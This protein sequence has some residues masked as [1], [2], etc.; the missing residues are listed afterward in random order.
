MSMK[1]KL[2]ELL[3]VLASGMVERDAAMRL[4]LLAALSGEHTLLI[5]P[6]GTAKSLLAERLH[7]AFTDARFF[8]RLVNKF[9]V[10]EDLFGPF[11]LQ[12]LDQGK[13]ERVTEGYMP[14]ASVVFLDEIFKANPAILNSLL[15]ILHER[16][17]DNGVERVDVPLIS[18]VAAS[19]ELPRPGELDA[20]FDRFLVR[21]PVGR[22]TDL[23]ALFNGKN[24][25]YQLERD[26]GPELARIGVEL[27]IQTNKPFQRDHQMLL[28]TTSHS[29]KGYEAEVVIVVGADQF[30]AKGA[31]VLANNLYVAMTRARS[32][33]TL[34][35][36]SRKHAE[37]T[38]LNETLE[39]CLDLLHERPAFAGE[40]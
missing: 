32:V 23:Q 39:S 31:G 3:T 25:R 24:I 30:C 34:F 2:Q 26:V 14:E 19:N 38:L 13:F 35:S 4:T 7:L 5:G 17:F 33:L 8:E 36:Q 11:N 21:C 28:A 37:G 9:T 1:E 12:Q 22:V 6:P 10:P 20:L 29:F 40:T 16:K 18:V 27:S 15:T